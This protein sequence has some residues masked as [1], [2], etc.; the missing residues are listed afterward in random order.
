MLKNPQDQKSILRRT[1]KK[2]FAIKY[3]FEK[4][5]PS[6]RKIQI[7][8]FKSNIEFNKTK[9]KFLDCYNTYPLRKNLV[10]EIS[11]DPQIGVGILSEESPL[12]P[13]LLHPR[14]DCSTEL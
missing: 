1:P 13:M 12:F 14:C 6:F 8:P 2:V 3:F 7:T 11:A 9:S 4:E 10:P 5:S